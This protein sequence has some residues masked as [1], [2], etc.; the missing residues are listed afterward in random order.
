MPEPID[1]YSPEQVIEAIETNLVQSTLVL[2]RGDDAVAFRGSDAIWVYTG[3]RGLSRVLRTRFL[4]DEAE[5]RVASIVAL[6]QRWNAHVSWILGPTSFPPE[7]PEYLKDA[8]FAP[9]QIW[10]GTA[11]SLTGLTDPG[12][13][14]GLRI[15]T[16]SSEENFQAWSSM[17][18]EHWNPADEAEKIFTAR[19]AGSD[20]HCRFYLGFLGKDPVVRGMVCTR[21]QVA[22]LYWVSA[23][24]DQR[25][26][27]YELSLA[28]KAL[29][30]A[31]GAGARLGVMPTRGTAS[32]LSAQL[33][34]EPYCQFQVFTWPPA[35]AMP[36]C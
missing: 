24:A 36:L 7:V 21:D 16:I 6:F 31:R 27:D 3:Y 29:L 14:S 8:G 17:S 32:T 34:F 28:T 4:I 9:A 2:D 11:G 35:S 15:E 30:D 25:G 1:H 12:K 13:A 19:T 5:D 23:R 26:K 22:G 18:S 20:P 10:M 33:G